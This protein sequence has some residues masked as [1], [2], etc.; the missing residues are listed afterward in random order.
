VYTFG[1]SLTDDVHFLD[2]M[3]YGIPIQVYIRNLH[4]DI[5]FIQGICKEFVKVNNLY[6]SRSL[7]TFISRPG[8]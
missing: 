1:Q 6:Y 7:Y 3:E 4:T 2:H 8:Y 5:G